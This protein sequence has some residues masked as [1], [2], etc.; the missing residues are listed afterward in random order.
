MTNNGLNR[1]KAMT[2]KEIWMAYRRER[3]LKK[4]LDNIGKFIKQIGGVKND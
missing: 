2:A 1:K 4:M 3:K